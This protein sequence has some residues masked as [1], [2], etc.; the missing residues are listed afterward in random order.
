M[1]N[2]QVMDIALE[3][4]TWKIEAF[5]K[6][7]T[8]KLSSKSFKVGGNRW[9]IILYPKGR[10]VDHLSLYITVADS[11]PPYGWSRFAYFRLALINQVDNNK[12]IVKETQQKFNAGNNGWGSPSFI[13]LS[14]FH[15]PSQGYLVNDTCIIEVHL[16]VS[17]VAFNINGEQHRPK[18]VK[19]KELEKTFSDVTLSPTSTQ[20]SKDGQSSE[21]E[22]QLSQLE[23]QGIGPSDVTPSPKQVQFVP[24]APPMYPLLSNEFEEV[25][26]IPVS[27]LIDFKS[28]EAEEESFIPLWK[29]VCSW[30]PSLVENQRR[31]SPRFILWAFIALGRVLLFLKTKKIRDMGGDNFMHLQVLWEELHSFGF[32]LT[33]LEPHV[34]SALDAKAYLQRAEHVKNLRVNVAT[35]EIEMRKLK[36]KLAVSELDLEVARRD[37]EEVENGFKERDMDAELGYGIP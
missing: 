17:K 22:V 24:S 34:H 16:S 7:N 29:E 12:S 19:T 32:D 14:E 11:L 5:S 9:K 1:E 3:K 6:V 28:L 25:L 15:D 21:I 20:N 4:F 26:L 27:D 35:L 2:Q 37:L 10:D 23:D 30:H 31:R 18:E 13:P 8:K 36:A 33:W